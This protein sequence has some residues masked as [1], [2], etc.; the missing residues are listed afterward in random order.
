VTKA[1]V[2]NEHLEGQF[3]YVFDH[4]DQIRWESFFNIVQTVFVVIV[5]ATGAM[6]FSRDVDRLVLV[7]IERMISK[8]ILIRQDPL[9]AIQLGDLQYKGRDSPE[10]SKDARIA[11]GRRPLLKRGGATDIGNLASSEDRKAGT[12]RKKG[13]QA[14]IA[15][16]H[17]KTLETKILENAIIKLGSLLA[18]GF[19]EAGS[20]IIGQNLDANNDTVD[21]MIPGSKVEAI[22]G[23]CDIRNFATTTEVLQEKT[24]VFVNQVAAIV[25]RIVDCHL[26]APNMNVGEAF[27]LVWRI[28]LYDKGLRS[29]IADV[30]VYSFVQVVA[31]V[32]RDRQLAQYRQHPALLAR[33]PNFRVN[34]GFGLHMGWSIEGAIGSEF[35]ID[36]SYLSPHVNIASRLDAATME[37]GVQILLS[38]PLVRS[39]TQAFARNFRP[40]DNVKLQGSTTAIRLFAVDLVSD[41][42]PVES[43]SQ[44]Q[45][46]H[47]AGLHRYEERLRREKIKTGLLQRSYEVAAVFQSDRHVQRMRQLFH[48]GF[49]QEFEKGY[50]NY[51]AGEWG[52]AATV[53]SRT[54][55]MLWTSGVCGPP[56]AWEDGPSRVL[57][58]YMATFDNK[59]PPG[60]RG[61]RE[62]REKN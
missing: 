58:E 20:E 11:P 39:C 55:R 18:L 14:T 19:G 12:P 30:A 28:G 42:L 22:Y 61:W 35:K 45:Q 40:V 46:R 1:A 25:H 2:F 27:L 10:T 3:V 5:L 32:S 53:L 15:G 23:F 6:L 16:K 50:L 21:A 44:S 29:K 7:P 13:V 41:M 47:V 56:G 48:I 26:G 37:Y 24:M 59:A 34:L 62:L 43:Q 33:L 51:E 17:K 52:I 36:A 8:V 57:L 49:F 38:E 9:Y 60:W 4:R 31:E 54:R